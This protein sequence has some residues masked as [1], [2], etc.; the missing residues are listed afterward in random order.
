[1]SK[2]F[3]I[4]AISFCVCLIAANLFEVKIFSAGLLTLTGGFLIFPVSYII[5][6]CLSEV[7]GYKKARF[8]ITAAIVMNAAFVLLAQ[9][10][11]KL[12]PETFWD[13]QEHIEYVFSADLRITLAS[14]AAFFFG[15]MLN[16]K[17][18][19]RLRERDGERRFG[20]RAILSTLAGESLDS[21]IFFPIAFYGVGT[22]NLI[23][24]MVTQ[25]VL[26]TLYEILVLPLTSFYV[27][28]LKRAEPSL[29]R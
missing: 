8:V 17:V 12:P 9:L 22:T 21:I 24:M 11:R 10:V 14:M 28:R 13:G 25:I 6:D 7:Y 4:L 26:K 27:R 23:V 29:S 18:M 2:R 1:M 20:W 16:A 3:T 15:S 19:S 5:N